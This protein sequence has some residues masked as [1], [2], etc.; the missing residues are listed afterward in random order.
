[1]S[2]LHHKH[3]V[4]SFLQHK[5]AEFNARLMGVEIPEVSDLT[6]GWNEH[7]IIAI[8]RDE[9]NRAFNE[10]P[11]T[12]DAE[13]RL[14]IPNPPTTLKCQTVSPAPSLTGI[15]M[16][17]LPHGM[18]D[19]L[20]QGTKIEVLE[21]KESLPKA[22]QDDLHTILWNAVSTQCPPVHTT[23]VTKVVN[24]PLNTR[25]DYAVQPTVQ[26]Q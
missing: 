4:Y 24:K 13:K 19:N 26:A 23:L 7:G 25:A 17:R 12:S 5:S 10:V 8:A 22:V 11:L 6:K 3:C 9:V 2:P 15:A 18:R 20:P 16:N 21:I 14:Y 1:M